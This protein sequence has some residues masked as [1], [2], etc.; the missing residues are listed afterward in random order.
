MKSIQAHV[1]GANNAAFFC[2]HCHKPFSISVTE[3]KDI[4]HT[5]TLRCNC[6]RQFRILLNFRRYQRKEVIIVGEAINLSQGSKAR[7]VITLMNLSMGGLRFKV[8][9]PSTIQ[10]GDKIRVRFTLDSPEEIQIDKEAI[11][12]NKVNNEYG[13]EFTSFSNQK[14]ELNLY[15]KNHST[16]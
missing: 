12:R 9:E 1:N 16:Q 6:S 13:C 7:T 4:K 15:L 8:L 14:K 2:P 10:Q 11:V 5:L 3:Y